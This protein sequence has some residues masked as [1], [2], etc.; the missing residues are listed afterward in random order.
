LTAESHPPVPVVLNVDDSDDRRRF[1][2]TVLR[3]SD[4]AVVEA[5]TGTEALRLAHDQRPSLVL[6]DVHL[7][8]LSGIE[9]CRRLK[10]SPATEAIPVLHVSAAFPDDMH[11]VE[12]LRGGA[13]RPPSPRRPARSRRMPR[14]CSRS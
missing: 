6:L 14:S 11:H 4:F 12:G 5:R 9:V 1:R 8:D 7:P 3:E 2:T 13:Y 10:A